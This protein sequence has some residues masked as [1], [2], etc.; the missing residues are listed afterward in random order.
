MASL[1]LFGLCLLF[2]ALILISAVV[3]SGNVD[4]VIT[5]LAKIPCASRTH[6]FPDSLCKVSRYSVRCAEIHMMEWGI[7]IPLRTWR[8]L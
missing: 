3:V 2:L 6:A 7:D 5:D 1:V 4:N 8:L